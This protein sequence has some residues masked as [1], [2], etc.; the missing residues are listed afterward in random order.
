MGSLIST[1]VRDIPQSGIRVIFHEAIKYRDVIH[2]EIGDPDFRTPTA[3]I[4]EAYKALLDG[5]THYTHNKGLYELREAISEYYR[6]RYGARFDPENNIVITLGS[7]EGLFLTLL[8][9]R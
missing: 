6:K 4:D 5:Y 1:W 9:V 8:G 3:L 7:T 2:L